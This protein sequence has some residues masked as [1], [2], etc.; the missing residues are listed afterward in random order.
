[1]IWDFKRL[2]YCSENRTSVHSVPHLSD[3][4]F[5]KRL[6][7]YFAQKTGYP[8]SYSNDEYSFYFEETYP[9]ERERRKYLDEMISNRVPSIG[10]MALAGLVRLNKVKRIWTT[11]F[12]RLVEDALVR[13][14]GST[15][16]FVVSTLENSKV[17]YDASTEDHRPIITKLHGDFLSRNIKNTKVELQQQ[18]SNL[19]KC[20]EKECGNYGIAFAG[21]SGRD[22]SILDALK[23]VLDTY[24]ENSFPSGFFWFHRPGSQLA[25]G[26]AE[27]FEEMWSLNIDAHPIECHTFD[28]LMRDLFTLIEDVPDEIREFLKVDRPRNRQANIPSAGISWPVIRLNAIPVSMAPTV[29]R[30]VVCE[31]GGVKEVKQAI[32]DAEAN[33]IGTRTRAGVICFGTDEDVR[34]AFE[35]HSIDV[36]DVHP[37]SLERLKFESAELGLLN[38]S[39]AKAIA[40]ETPLI[41]CRSRRG[42]ILHVDGNQTGDP[43]LAKL[44]DAEGL[45]GVIPGTKNRWYTAILIRLHYKLDQLWLV[46]E[47]TVKI[48]DDQEEEI[49]RN[50]EAESKRIES[51]KEFIRERSAKRYNFVLNNLLEGCTAALCGVDNKSN[52]ATFQS[53]GI[54]DGIDAK[55]EVCRTTAY[56]KRLTS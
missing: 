43:R 45:V 28:E 17:G 52:S 16:K 1:M 47:P 4:E 46:F 29:C 12:D 7:A 49:E 26:V 30:K 18:E 10:H 40:R 44:A 38:E 14:L 24:K 55:F 50:S 13:T 51:V 5:R 27:L 15:E 8:P 3:V 33:V 32:K 39:I 2:L 31:I 56:S 20:L 37:I 54:S 36:F 53:L 41:A 11:N 6:T 22:Q 48:Q 42:W 25:P 34:R 9:D 19:R 23:T 21:Y 35:D